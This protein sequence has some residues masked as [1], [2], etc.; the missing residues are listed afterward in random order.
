[1][2]RR[3]NTTQRSIRIDDDLWARVQ[4]QAGTEG[5][6]ASTL[7]RQLLTGWLNMKDDNGSGAV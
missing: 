5:I 2:T 3:G 1:M 7:I 6:D 4:A